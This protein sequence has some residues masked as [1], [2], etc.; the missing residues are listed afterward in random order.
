MAKLL[1]G[2]EQD[3]GWG[4]GVRRGSWLLIGVLAALLAAFALK[5]ALVALP[6]IPA[7][8]S[9]DAFDAN[10]AHGRLARI[11][12]GVGAH[13]VD[14]DAGDLVRSRLAAEMRAVGL[15]PRETDSFTCN[16]RETGRALACGRVRN[17][18][19][20]IGPA[21]GRHL[22]IV[23]H[24]DSTF[25][26][27]G[28]A[29]A[30]IGYATMLEVA[31]LLRGR[32][33]GRP[34][35]FLFDDGE[36]SGLLG[37][38]AFLDGDPLAGQVDTLINL[39]AR[40]VTGP[41]IMF[42]TSRPNGN[43]I[44][45]LDAAVA[46]PVANSLST[47]F[48]RLIP[49]STDVAV[50]ERRRWTVLNF[51]VIGD[52][53]RYHSAGDTLEALDR[54]SLQ[55]MGDQTL[56]L[57][58]TIASGA[59]LP[60][61]SGNLI[62]A[63]LLGRTLAVV[64]QMVGLVLLGALL[65]LFGV[66]AWLRGAI[67]RPL[68]AAALSIAGA[69]FLAFAATFLIGQM[70]GGDWWRAYP[71]AAHM[72]VHASA[73]LACMLALAWLGRRADRD[74]LRIAA[75]LVF[76]I[77]GAGLCFAAPGAA[78]FFL[79]PPLLAALGALMSRIVPPAE[80]LGAV[81]AGLAAFLTF[82][83]TLALLELLL[84]DGPLWLLAVPAALVMLPL[85]VEALP[86]DSA[87]RLHPVPAGLAALVLAGWA[88]VGLLPRGTADRQQLFTIEY[89]RDA[90]T[91]EALWAV[92]NKTAAL[93]SVF[94]ASGDWRL[95]EFP[96]STRSRW[97][98]PAPALPLAPPSA[99]RIG[100]SAVLNGRR[101]SLR[102]DANGAESYLIRAAADARIVA[103]GSGGTLHPF[104]RGEGDGRYSIRC[105]GRSCE[106]RTFDFVVAGAA[107]AELTIIGI[108]SGL[109]PAAAPLVAAR[110][111]HSRPQYTPDSTYAIGRITL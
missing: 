44:A 61:R 63:D 75:W 6:A 34:V 107:P 62:Y 41:A 9:P 31:A 109:P 1:G 36:E 76:L 105:T 88:A 96:F 14:S 46:R 30:G 11:L 79:A 67:G 69:P 65:L 8:P 70:R 108:R 56:A 35:T 15:Q 59:V 99:E 47:D 94:A 68:Y 57:T 42:E 33:L 4:N 111:E 101:V 25:A 91:G 50:F 92:S 39:E 60:E 52:E 49:N 23:A 12:A 54:R 2:Q 84:I 73:L 87:E 17:L 106:G 86:G 37:A 38:R 93:P 27:P 85:L 110:P 100:E 26:G 97:S 20:T 16:G 29:D 104:G 3:T 48:Y 102:I 55:H 83:P 7:A 24:T 40:G 72:A 5:G 77:V 89:I 10:R 80:R 28:A 53:T 82:S 13:P 45:A 58:R 19:A 51:A 32:Q 66:T 90:A 22:L 43:A 98:A 21:E 78:I 64:P 74:Q 18:V 81:L 95:R 71:L 103:A